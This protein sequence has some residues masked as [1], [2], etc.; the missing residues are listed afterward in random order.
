MSI[1][2]SHRRKAFR[3]G[4]GGY[5]VDDYSPEAAYS[6]REV[7]SA[8]VGVDIVE[9]L[10]SSDSARSYFTA[11]EITD[12][13]LT[14]WVG[15]GNDGRVVTLVDQTGSGNDLIPTG[16]I[17]KPRIVISGSLV[18]DGGL[19]SM[20]YAGATENSVQ[21]RTL[22]TNSW[23]SG[24][25]F[26]VFCVA[27]ANSATRTQ[28]IWANNVTV[29]GQKRSL[30]GISSNQLN[31]VFWGTNVNLGSWTAGNQS[32]TSTIGTNMLTGESHSVDL[33][34]DGSAQTGWSGTGKTTPASSQFVLGERVA[35]SGANQDF[36]GKIAECIV[37]AS[38][39]TSNRSAI[40]SNIT[41][42]YGIT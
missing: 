37:F 36:D 19:P 29:T 8:Y 24:S 18:T 28:Y 16:G 6:L 27:N 1:H 22:A 23:L 15:A 2:L 41:T 9:V 12:G 20:D 7:A 39:Q 13:T 3:G 42:H 31:I 5:I 4:A 34:V 17:D 21:L 33:W 26:S 40:D 32:L 35:G 25:D 38:D 30:I 11:T 10:R 14:T